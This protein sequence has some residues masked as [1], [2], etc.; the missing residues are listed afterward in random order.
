M[1]LNSAR[2]VGQHELFDS[3]DPAD[4]REAKAICATCPAIS[5]CRVRVRRAQ[6]AAP[7]GAGPQGTWAGKLF[8]STSRRELEAV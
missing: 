8:G 5:A 1:T 3:R 6:L 2:C 4:H 7:W